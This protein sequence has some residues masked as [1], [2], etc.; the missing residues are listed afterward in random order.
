MRE[1][2]FL[3]KKNSV[4]PLDLQAPKEP[5]VYELRYKIKGGTV[6]ATHSFTVQ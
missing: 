6:I 5:G 3:G 2:T 4:S 1:Y